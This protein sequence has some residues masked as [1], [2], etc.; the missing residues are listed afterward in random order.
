MISTLRLH[1]LLA[2]KH[3]CHAHTRTDTHAR[4]ENFVAILLRD[5]QACRYLTSASCDDNLVTKSSLLKNTVLTA[6]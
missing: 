1:L 4:H 2:Y 6:A 3:S 5:V